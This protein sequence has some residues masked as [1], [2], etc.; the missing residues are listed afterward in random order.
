MDWLQPLLDWVSRHPNWTLAFVYAG[1][2]GE[3]IL[4]LGVL[5]PTTVV[6]VAAG[7]FV[8]LGSLEFWPVV[9]AAMAGAVTGDSINFWIGRHYGERALQSRFAQ[10]YA[11]AIERSREL[12]RRHGAKALIFARFV[13]LVRPFIAA[14]AGGYRMP[15]WR[16]LAVEL[17]G[18]FVWAAP[19][20]VVGL[21]FGA[22]L[23]L[24]AEVATRLVVILV[25][26]LVVVWVSVWLAGLA[27]VWV[28]GHGQALVHGLLDW[29]HRH[30]RLGRLGEWLAD[31]QQPETPGLAIL[32]LALLAIGALWLWLWWGLGAN[33]PTAL[34][35]MAWQTLRELHTPP[36]L[37]LSVALAQLGDWRVYVPVAVSVLVV[38]LVLRRPL[39]AWHWLAAIGFASVIAL[40]LTLLLA[41]P[42]PLEYYRG[43]PSA[44]FSGRDLVL[45]TVVYGF[46]PVVL[47]TGRSV[48]VRSLFYGASVSLIALIAVG[49]MYVGSQWLSVG[50]FAVVIGSVWVLLLGLGYRRHGAAPVPLRPV[51]L[52]VLGTFGLAAA[53][54]WSNA[55][56]RDLETVSVQPAQPMPMRAWWNHG[57]G[58]LPAYRIDVAGVFK[59]PLNV[60]WRGELADIEGDLRS[61]GWEPIE[62]LD[63]RTTLR[64]L[65]RAPIAQLPLLPQIHAGAEPA[66]TLRK[67]IDDEN[68]WL[69]RLWPTEWRVTG[70]PLWI[71]NVT[72]QHVR[73]LLRLV[74]YPAARRDYAMPLRALEPPPPGVRKKDV[75]HTA[76]DPS[77]PGWNGEV[78]LLRSDP[79]P[80]P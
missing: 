56:S 54:S 5:I 29:S 9:A 14:I 11:E 27:V 16:F 80:P 17:F 36:G 38:L 13:G 55:F 49:Q 4:L 41:L 78:R 42:D 19:L 24:A 45:A 15:V 75:R 18:A 71:G 31:P 79:E 26:V 28:Q 20:I 63:W 58:K 35:A 1:C 21:A 23:G 43:N 51:V 60:Q 34:D 68:Q 44:R 30:R 53:L 57:Y 70:A 48:A 46:L 65:S 10:R 74:H 22:S 69:L 6:L 3:S 8:A 25:A 77:V 37:A 59:Q 2:T 61:A 50:L 76:R 66:L 67:P 64:W 12:F 47:G 33:H 62:P 39:A 72:S 52:P 73:G 7:A 40:G 32:A